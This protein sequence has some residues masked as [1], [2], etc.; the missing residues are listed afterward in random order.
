MSRVPGMSYGGRSLAAQWGLYRRAKPTET[1]P[2]LGNVNP[3]GTAMLYCRG[4]IVGVVNDTPNAI[5]Y[6]FNK[7]GADEARSRVPGFAMDVHTPLS[8][9]MDR[10]FAAGWMS[11]DK[12][13]GLIRVKSSRRA[14]AH[15][16]K[17]SK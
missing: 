4:K 6:A 15:M 8:V 16:R 1:P 5:A 10:V 2:K 9:G 12:Q 17:R 7:T 3:C 14:K 11:S 13:A